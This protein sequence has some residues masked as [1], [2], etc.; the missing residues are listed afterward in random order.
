[1]IKRFDDFRVHDTY[2]K[3]IGLIDENSEMPEL[4]GDDTAEVTLRILP[5][6]YSTHQIFN[7]LS[8][9]NF[10]P[11]FT[12]GKFGAAK[13]T[14]PLTVISPDSNVRSFATRRQ[15]LTI[16]QKKSSMY[17][18]TPKVSDQIQVAARGGK[19]FGARKIIDGKPVHL[20]L[21]RYPETGAL[22]QIAESL[23][24]NIGSEWSRFRVG[25]TESGPILLAMENFKLKKP[26]LVDLYFD[27]YET[28][29]GKIPAWY[30]H[31]VKDQQL[32]SYLMEY[33][34]RE[35]ISKKCPYIL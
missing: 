14:P 31:K 23:Y 16:P 22:Q 7:R 6:E 13:L 29:L 26:E 8:G 15:A 17:F 25:L 12:V 1:M 2:S 11:K 35:E 10:I 28:V 9:N 32:K 21:T 34:N 4:F 30:R 19:I 5:N 33:I 24:S 18:T 27:V 20:D 3:R